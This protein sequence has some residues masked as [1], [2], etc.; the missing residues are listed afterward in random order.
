MQDLGAI[1]RRLG[2]E[3]FGDQILC[4]GPG[5]F[6]PLDRSLSVK[7]AS[8]GSF[9]VHSFAGDDWVACR[10]HVKSRIGESPAPQPI[11]MALPHETEKNLGRARHLWS[12]R[13]PIP[14]TPVETYLASRGVSFFG[15]SLGYLEAG[16]Y[17]YPAMIAAFGVPSEPEPGVIALSDVRGIHLTFLKHDGSGKADV[18]RAKRML[19]P[20]SSFPIAVAPINDL[21][22]LSISEGIEDAISAYEATGRGSWAAGSAGRMAALATRIP[23]Y[24]ETVT[25]FA[26]EDAAGQRGAYQLADALANLNIEALIASV[27]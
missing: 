6:S 20:S 12:C 4:P 21:L 9:V 3:A 22:G 24:V 17:P 18:D 14:G 23:G 15:E 19:G 16:S 7:F 26:D 11:R 1:A 13:K 8:D 25:I 5:H 27:K 2:G 10:D